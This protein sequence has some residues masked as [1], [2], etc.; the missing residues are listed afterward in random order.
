MSQYDKTIHK[1]IN[2]DDVIRE[3]IKEH[4]GK[5]LQIAD[6]LYRISITGGSVSGKTN[7]LFNLINQ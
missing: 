7:S 5:W 3:N 6:H 4:N 2:F 1:M